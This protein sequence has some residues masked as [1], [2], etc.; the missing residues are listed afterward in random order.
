MKHIGHSDSFF[1]VGMSIFK[2][3]TLSAREKMVYVVLCSFADNKTG[4]CFPSVH[5]IAKRAGLN[6][7]LTFKALAQLEVM[8]LITITR[9]FGQGNYYTLLDH[10]KKNPK[11]SNI[12]SL[13]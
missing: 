3:S 4:E 9:H 1:Q 5:T 8:E 2:M 10:R 7:N 6:Y 12:I 11:K 13:K